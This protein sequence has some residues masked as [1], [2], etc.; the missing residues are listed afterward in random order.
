MTTRRIKS[1]WRASLGIG[2]AAVLG[3]VL[4]TAVAKHHSIGPASP[5][6]AVGAA[7]AASALPGQ[8]V[9]ATTDAPTSGSSAPAGTEG[10]N[11]GSSPA[12]ASTSAQAPSHASAPGAGAAAAQPSATPT[13]TPPP[14]SG[15]CLPQPD[16]QDTVCAWG[17][18]FPPP[19]P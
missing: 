8:V 6:D 14:A 17:A 15:T 5:A 18:G 3:A 7:S 2:L 16:P 11:R 10:A 1:A 9:S 19:S 4:A 12:S 13:P